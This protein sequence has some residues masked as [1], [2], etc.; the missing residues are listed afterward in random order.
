MKVW[1]R[2]LKL[3]QPVNLISIITTAIVLLMSVTLAQT[4]MDEVYPEDV[5]YCQWFVG[6]SGMASDDPDELQYCQTILANTNG[7]FSVSD[8]ELEGL[9]YCRSFLADA[10]A[11]QSDPIEKELCQNLI[12]LFQNSGG[13]MASVPEVSLDVWADDGSFDTDFFASMTP[14]QIQA[15][16]QNCQPML[17]S[18]TDAEFIEQCTTAMAI[19]NGSNAS[20]AGVDSVSPPTNLEGASTEATGTHEAMIAEIMGSGEEGET[21]SIETNQSGEV[22]QTNQS[23][24]QSNPLAPTSANPLNP[25]AVVSAPAPFAGSFE[26]DK[27]RL[28]LAT[29]VGGGYAG[30]L[31]IDGQSFPV[32][33]QGLENILNGV[34]NAS[35]NEF[36]FSAT[37]EGSSLELVSDG[38]QFMLEKVAAKNPLGN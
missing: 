31:S 37:L 4:S 26:G 1:L 23:V 20:T 13:D 17:E 7:Q 19:V 18:T 5:V 6:D 22:S 28:D 35:G 15:F 34:F 14:E 25:L 10:T 2:C 33:A 16:V 36:A 27:L 12:A 32:Q 9:G 24:Q 30:M 38:N 21:D 8:F 3:T 11:V 29:A